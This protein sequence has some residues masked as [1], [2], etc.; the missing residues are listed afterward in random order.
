VKIG[1][2]GTQIGMTDF[3]KAEFEKII[4]M[5]IGE[6]HHGDCI[7]ADADAHDIAEKYLTCVIHPP[8]KPEKR[9][10]KKATIVHEKKPYLNRNRDIVNSCELLIATPKE[11]TNQTRSGTWWTIRYAKK[12]KR[13]CLI[14]YPYMIVDKQTKF[15]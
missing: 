8:I 6:F 13:K 11:I 4:S 5:Y 12:I 15:F 14:I 1:F 2:T 7:G 3:Q 10:F 9:A